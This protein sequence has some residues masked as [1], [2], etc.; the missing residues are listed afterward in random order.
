MF[1]AAVAG[2]GGPRLL[3]VDDRPTLIAAR[4]EALGQMGFRVTAATSTDDAVDLIGQHAR[5][6]AVRTDM[7]RVEPPGELGENDPAAG[8][9]LLAHVRYNLKSDIQVVIV[10]N[11]YNQRHLGLCAGGARWL[12]RSRE[13]W[14]RRPGGDS[15]RTRPEAVSAV[16]SAAGDGL[17]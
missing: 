1:G 7:G 17:A 5:Y 13:R 2:S 8:L 10:I 4:M 15:Q 3:W 12:R 11:E 9:R 16:P 14:R 6:A